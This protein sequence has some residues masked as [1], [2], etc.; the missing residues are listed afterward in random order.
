MYRLRKEIYVNAQSDDEIRIAITEN[1]HLVELFVETPETERRVGD[2]FMG[3]IAKVIPGMNAAFINVGLGQDAFLHFTDVGDSFSS[4]TAFLA[5]EDAELS[6]DDEEEDEEYLV[7]E[8]ATANE[9]KIVRPRNRN[10]SGRDT[11]GRSNDRGNSGRGPNGGG[12]NDRNRRPQRHIP[13][14]L[15]SN[16][17]LESGSDIL[18]QVTREA[19]A[20]KGVRVT[21]RISLPGRF[22][23]LVPFEPGIG[24]SKKVYSVRERSR[25]RRV[26]RSIKPREYGVIIRTV[27]EN[28]EESALREDLEQLLDQWK[29]IEQ[30][31]KEEKAPALLFQDTSLTSSVMRDLFSQDVSRI[32][33]DSKKMH[34]ELREYV[35]W[36]APNLTGTVEL[37][38]GSKAMFDTFNIEAQIEQTMS[39]KVPLPSGGYLFIEHTEAMVVI[40]VNSGRYA[41]RREQ[42]LNSLKTNLEAA[43]ETA[44]QLRLRDIGG[45]IVIDFIDMN[46]ERNR[47]KVYD[48][49][50]KELRNDRA[51]SSI[52]PLTEFGLMQITRQ[53]IRQSIV[54]SLSEEC[55]ICS[56][57]GRLVSRTTIIRQIERW[58]ERFR[59][60]SNERKLVMRVSPMLAEMLTRGVFSPLRNLQ[61]K[62]LVRIKLEANDTFSG[63]EFHFFSPRQ[64]RNI[65]AEYSATASLRAVEA[66]MDFSEEEDSDEDDH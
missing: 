65:T 48:E 2:I 10:G 47:K 12:S 63:D 43:R 41:A 34:K 22:V 6:D 5:G 17:S 8:G 14:L 30:K 13:T 52:L 42:E 37:Y 32:V 56:G 39:N 61:L 45:I 62:Y 15:Q 35:E 9:Q 38:R 23:V 18:V 4:S 28:K 53:R 19:Y 27:A 60:G 36:A 25:L 3:K 51:K 33:I 49:M 46:E 7:E 54:Q 29:G 44:R 50:K 55:P 64:K 1:D 31:I 24:I 21:S 26:I 40:D 59:A 57:T 58:L 11:D 20:N 16:V 66:Q